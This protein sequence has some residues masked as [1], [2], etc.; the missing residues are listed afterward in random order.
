[1]DAA[2]VQQLVSQYGTAANGGVEYWSLDNEPDLWQ[3]THHHVHPQC[4]SY[5]EIFEHNRDA[6]AALK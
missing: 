3:D 4:V 6:A 5:D 2:W 1:M